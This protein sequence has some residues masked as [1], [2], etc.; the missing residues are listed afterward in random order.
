[1]PT[2][3]S[4]APQPIGRI[5]DARGGSPKIPRSTADLDSPLILFVREDGDVVRHVRFIFLTGEQ[6]AG[7]CADTGAPKRSLCIVADPVAN[8]SAKPGADQ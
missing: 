7:R 1:M 8:R 6:E 3:E 4:Q 2:T 5:K